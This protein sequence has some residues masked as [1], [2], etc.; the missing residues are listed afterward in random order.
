MEVSMAASTAWLQMGECKGIEE[1]H[2]RTL[3]Q[4]DT[5]S[6]TTFQTARTAP[7]IAE[8]A[9]SQAGRLAGLWVV[10]SPR[11]SPLACSA[12]RVIPVAHRGGG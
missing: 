8:D 4:N 11:Q 2:V 3:C 1:R 5:T 9:L 10:V 12:G 7:M 6:T